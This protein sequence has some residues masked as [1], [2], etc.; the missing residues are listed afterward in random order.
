M[1][2]TSAHRA[3]SSLVAADSMYVNPFNSLAATSTDATS[4]AQ[5]VTG[6]QT[7]DLAGEFMHLHNQNKDNA[8]TLIAYLQSQD[9]GAQWTPE[10]REKALSTCHDILNAREYLNRSLA[11]DIET[12]KTHRIDIT[13]PI[14]G[15]HLTVAKQ[16]RIALETLV[17]RLGQN[18]R[19]HLD[20]GLEPLRDHV[21]QLKQSCRSLHAEQ[22]M[23]ICSQAE[24]LLKSQESFKPRDVA[25]L[26]I[27][28][29]LAYAARMEKAVFETANAVRQLVNLERTLKLREPGAGPGTEANRRKWQV[30]M[31]AVNESRWQDA[32][33]HINALSRLTSTAPPPPGTLHLVH[34]S[35]GESDS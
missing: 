25:S 21:E 30:A 35:P 33:T 5:D 9:P 11:A 24:Q 31:D 20:R 14:S 3:V 28:S 7:S 8:R 27:A 34:Q 26:S 16:E 2:A 1:P 18:A 15:H 17:W 23:R 32:E 13:M 29:T 12:G 19:R 10:D 22:P 6:P 4:A